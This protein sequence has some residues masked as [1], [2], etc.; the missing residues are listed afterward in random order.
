MLGPLTAVARAFDRDPELPALV[1]RLVCVG[2]AWHEPG[3]ASA[4]AEFHFYCDPVAAR[5]VLKSGVPITMVPLDVTRKAV[6]SPSE[7]LEMTSRDSAACRFLGR[8]ASYGIRTTS[9]LYGVEGLY[10]KD[11]LGI[12]VVASPGAFST[13]PMAVDVEIRGE[14][15]LGMSVVDAR[16]TRKNSTNVDLAVSVEIA[17]VR[18]YI[19]R[20][21]DLTIGARP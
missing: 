16:P 11:V 10:L 6:F 9:N 19:H 13:K 2:G 15:T 7:L 18:E 1:Q 21:L 20:I 14:L 17:P 4:L 12:A 5:Q 8:I 3:N